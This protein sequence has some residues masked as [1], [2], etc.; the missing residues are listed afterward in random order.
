ML[1]VARNYHFMALNVLLGYIPLE[2]SF[3]YKK[4]NNQLFLLL[5]ILWLLFY[6][7]APYLFTDFFHLENLS[8]YQGMNQ[9][10][11]QSLSAWFSFSLLTVG[12]CV[13][14][15]LG[16]ATVFT[17]LNECFQRNILNKKWQGFLF[18]MIVNVLS[19]LAI[20][21]GR[22]DRLHSVHLLTKPIQT[23]QIIFFNC[24]VN[25]VLFILLFTG[26]QFLLLAAIFGLKGLRL[27][28]EGEM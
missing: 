2:L 24:S 26:M 13:Y 5:G 27:V 6:P 17:T 7:N 1:F 28:D 3:H 16:M 20:F 10:F 18:I 14:G 11:G 25:K 12:I 9:I 15:L 23:L 8:I 4:V 22:F 19:S 21:V